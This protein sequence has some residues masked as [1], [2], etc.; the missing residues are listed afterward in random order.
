MKLLAKDEKILF[1][2]IVT[3][4][5]IKKECD[6][7]LTNKRIIIKP[8]ALFSNKLLIFLDEIVIYRNKIKLEQD[9]NKVYMQNVNGNLLLNFDDEKKATKFIDA[10]Y[11]ALGLKRNKINVK[12]VIAGAAAVGAVAV[13][14]RVP[15]VGNAVAKAAPAVGKAVK[16]A[17]P[18]V[19]EVAALGAEKIID[20]VSEKI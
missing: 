14:G 1:E 13:A 4:N 19:K 12:S 16:T 15:V 8:K 2:D 17:A 9:K 7:C 3:Y 20:K 10:I 5:N 11:N 6:L 18:I